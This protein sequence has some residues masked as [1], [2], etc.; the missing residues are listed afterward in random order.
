MDLFHFDLPTMIKTV[1]YVGLFAIIFSESCF[2][3][4]LPGDS[5]LFTA[6][7]LASQGFLDLGLLNALLIVAAIAGNQVGYAFGYRV[8]PRLFSREDSLL[9]HRKHLDRTHEFYERHGGKAIVLARFLPIVRTFAPIV[10]G[11]GR[12]NYQ[13]FVFFNVVGALL[14]IVGLTV[15]GY[16]IGNL[17]PDVDRYLLPIIVLI[18]AVSL[19]P[20]VWHVYRDNR[21]E[22][23]RFV[24]RRTG[25]EE[26]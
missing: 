13:R 3:F 20:S 17:I 12:M 22:V 25:R 4:F 21:E 7:F 8:G 14:W 16:L 5:L 1:G 10:A 2:A 18:I 15:G 24:R 11:V 26:R 19:A 9:F 6:G 23:H